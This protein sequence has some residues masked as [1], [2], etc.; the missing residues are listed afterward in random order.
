MAQRSILLTLPASW[1]KLSTLIAAIA[2]N[3]P[4]TCQF[5]E[6]ISPPD[7]A[8]GS[9][10]QVSMDPVELDPA[11]RIALGLSKLIESPLRSNNLST[12]DK[13]IRLSDAGGNSI[14]GSAL[15]VIN[16]A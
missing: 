10:L 16:Y 12:I 5:M 15:I 1:Q 6:I 11:Y 3:L 14:E 4:T 7:N 8:A 2:P 13:W 9:V